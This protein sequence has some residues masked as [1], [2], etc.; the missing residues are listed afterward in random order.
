[1]TEENEHMEG[2]ARI[3]S[4][5]DINTQTLSNKI[6]VDIPEFAFWSAA[7]KPET[8]H[9]GKFGLAKHTLEVITTMFAVK[10]VLPKAREIPDNQIFLAGLFHDIGKVWDYKPT[11]SEFTEWTGTNHKRTIHHISRSALVWSKS[12]DETGL[13]QKEHD[14]ILHA[15]LSHHGCREWGSP[16]SPA[17]GLAWLL[18]LSD[19][20]SARIEDSGKSKRF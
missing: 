14:D 17:T 4:S 8:H 3:S 16:V 19:N 7:S 18:H 12:V 9:Y 20:L 6:L 11:N 1:M 2:L 5:L 15:I 13:F 10:Q